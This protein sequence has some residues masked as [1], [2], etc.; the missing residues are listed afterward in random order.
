M[1]TTDVASDTIQNDSQPNNHTMHPYPENLSRGPDPNPPPRFPPTVPI[2]TAILPC[3]DAAVPD[4]LD[5]IQVT[6]QDYITKHLHH[7]NTDRNQKNSTRLTLLSHARALVRALETPRETMIKH[8]WAEPSA[9]MCLAVGVDT[10]LFHYLSCNDAGCPCTEGRGEE[11]KQGR[12]EGQEEE[13]H[14]PP[15][16][17]HPSPDDD[18]TPDPSN[19]TAR[20]DS[21]DTANGTHH[22]SHPG[23]PK[24]LT[25]LSTRTGIDPSLLS[26]LLRHL[27]SMSHIRQPTPQTFLPTPFS[28]SLT[29]PIISDGYPVIHA[30]LPALSQ[31]PTYAKRTG[32]REPC[33]PENGPYQF[34]VRTDRGFFED[35]A[36]KKPL[37][38][39][40]GNHMGG[41][42]QGRR[43]WW[44]EGFYPVRERVVDGAGLDGA[45]VDGDGEE[46]KVLLVDVGGS[47]GH[48]IR[49]FAAGFGDVVG[50]GRGRGRLILEDLP[51]VV[52]QIR[53]ESSVVG[54]G[55]GEEVRIE[56]VGC[57]FF[58]ENPVQGA[59]AYY[60][61]SVLHDWP[62]PLASAILSRIAQAMKPGYSKLL[63]NENCI[64]DRGA[65][66]EATALDMM[67]LGLVAS[68]ERTEREWRELI[69]G[70]VRGDGWRLKVVGIW[71]GGEEE[72][73][74]SLIECE[75][76]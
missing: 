43:S 54:S 36:V 19:P 33:D 8:C 76:V 34:G 10:G 22:P 64:P 53:E 39:L 3:D 72:G 15:T 28:S 7:D 9:A 11:G 75:L 66:W 17:S 59:R 29:H 70:T 67:M 24:S 23:N 46:G 73:V 25:T 61:H 27:T 5:R 55:N 42:R 63:I 62:N 35:Q 48:D 4:L 32:Y 52:G 57:D 47:F 16:I 18:K 71:G 51:E 44:E 38:E 56:R 21:S 2:Q 1:G 68:K 50:S 69:E 49:E 20:P 65:H 60:L 45:E 31:F 6:G 74:E 12:G 30:S 26:R 37:L 41:Y 13:T 58:K 14:P 40:F